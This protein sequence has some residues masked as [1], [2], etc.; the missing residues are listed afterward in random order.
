ME[1]TVAINLLC[2]ALQRLMIHPEDEPLRNVVF[3]LDD[4]A[5]RPGKPRRE[6]FGMDFFSPLHVPGAALRVTDVDFR[7][8]ARRIFLQKGERR[9]RYSSAAARAKFQVAAGDTA[10]VFPND[11]TARRGRQMYLVIVRGSSPSHARQQQ[12]REKE[13][14]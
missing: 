12:N 3:G 4:V 9:R 11:L 2:R 6:D 8:R 7:G 14:L 13:S 1:H 10:G 5:D